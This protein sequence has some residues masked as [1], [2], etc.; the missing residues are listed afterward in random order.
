MS[1]AK[2]G[3]LNYQRKKLFYLFLSFGLGAFSSQLNAQSLDYNYL[4]QS[5]DTYTEITND[6]ILF[7]GNFDD[8]VSNGIPI[9]PVTMGVAPHTTLHISTNGFLTLSVAAA[10]NNYDPLSLGVGAPVIAPFATNLEST[11]ASSKVSYTIDF[12]G[13]TIQWK[14]VRRV[15]YPGESFSF[16]ARI[17][18]PSLSGFGFGA[19]SFKYD[20]F[21]G[22]AAPSTAVHVGIRV[23]NGDTPGLFSTR[24]VSQG[25]AWSPDV[26]GTSSTSTCAFP[27]NANSDGVPVSGMQHQWFLWTNYLGVNPDAFPLCNGNGN[28]VIYSNYDGGSLN[29]NVDQNIPNLKIGI[30]TYEPVQVNISGPFV[31]NVTQVLYAG[32]NSNAGNNHCGLGIFSSS[33]SGV[34]PAITE[35]QT[36]PPLGFDTKHGNG[37]SG[38]GFFNGSGLMVGV[39]GQC[40]TLYPAGGGNTPDE[41]VLY[42][43]NNLGD[44]LLFHHTQYDCW[45]SETYNI[46][47]GGTCCI[48]PLAPA[49]SIEMPNDTTLCYGESLTLGPIENVNGQAPFTYEWTFNNG[50]VCADAS[51]T[52]VATEDGQACVTV[53]DANGQTLSDCFSVSVDPQVLIALSVSDTALCMPAQFILSNDTDPSTFTS[54]QWTINGAPY[55]NLNTAT[56][57]PDQPGAFDVMLEVSTA[58]GCAYDTL[59]NNYITS[60]PQ[61]QANYTTDPL[62]LYPDNTD[63]TLIDLSSGNIESWL[64]TISLP[65]EEIVSTDQSPE[66]SLPANFEGT[67]PIQ[68]EVTTAEGCIDSASGL[69][70]IN[71]LFNLY[72]PNAFTP[73]DDGLNDVFQVEGTGIN[74][75]N[76]Q[77]DVYNRWGDTVFSTT[78]PQ[79]AWTGGAN[80]SSYYCP[81]GAYTYCISAYSL[82]SGER[83]EYRGSVSIIR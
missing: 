10:A 5:L 62:I 53:T 1:S 27:S 20:S 82:N 19:I 33:I 38:S 79:Q 13:I 67:Y 64:W 12:Q 45:L 16:Q 28:L 60:F 18:T 83:F 48:N 68:L 72:I 24:E 63:I 74:T 30:C 39:S 73:N 6:V 65:S 26:A 36:A 50:V 31:G 81:N 11:G 51:C 40:D 22:V 9:L 4:F 8:G 59:I 49:W 61:P 46:S 14:N 37:Q 42:F 55:S 71:E 7:S 35:I 25:N 76:F 44:E 17:V 58:N 3:F 21:Q 2:F 54:Q 47:D 29:I 52:V 15:G 23:G 78:D 41:V 57:V 56:F 34:N 43:L 70:I 80:G 66:L 69:I 75:S 77:L 32:F